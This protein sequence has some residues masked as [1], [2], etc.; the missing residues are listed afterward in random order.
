MTSRG[1]IRIGFNMEGIERASKLCLMNTSSSIAKGRETKQTNQTT[2]STL[3][4]QSPKLEGNYR[5]PYSPTYKYKIEIFFNFQQNQVNYF[6]YILKK[7]NIPLN[8]NMLYT[9]KLLFFSKYN[10]SLRKKG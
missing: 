5:K 9:I 10:L 1:L 2:N 3:W 6:C 4:R 8:F 7:I